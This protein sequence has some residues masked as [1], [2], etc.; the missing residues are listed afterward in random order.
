MKPRKPDGMIANLADAIRD[1]TPELQQANIRAASALILRDEVAF[2]YQV[3]RVL[4]DIQRT[5]RA[6]D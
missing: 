3:E 6:E 5:P 2:R 1:M 4:E